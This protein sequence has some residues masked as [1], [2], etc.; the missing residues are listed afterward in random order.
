MG[1]GGGLRQ[2]S[3]YAVMA[4]LVPLSVMAGLVPFSVMAGHSPS[5]TGV[6]ALMPGHPRLG[7]IQPRKDV[8][9]RN[10][11]GHDGVRPAMTEKG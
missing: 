8:D 4:G 5:K 6:N 7:L 10:K 11:C 3:T 1:E 2:S 9:A